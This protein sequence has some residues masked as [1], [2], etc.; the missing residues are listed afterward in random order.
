MVY[1]HGIPNLAQVNDN[2][3]RS[4]QIA[5]IEGWNYLSKI[6][7]GR[8]I[9]IIK[10]NS[11][12]EGLD[13]YGRGMGMDIIYIPIPPHDTNRF[14]RNIE[15]IVKVPNINDIIAIE[16]VLLNINSKDIYLVHCTHG[17]DRTGIVIGIFR[18]LNGWDKDKAYKEML[19]H[20]FHPELIG[21]MKLWEQVIILNALEVNGYIYNK[22]VTKSFLYRNVD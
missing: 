12:D 6:A 20:D 8:K 13:N 19:D 22:E 7:N 5:S 15:E 10:L 14:I 11:D 1:T 2:I 16:Q 21:L 18:I 17:Q 4:G 3:Y 9:H